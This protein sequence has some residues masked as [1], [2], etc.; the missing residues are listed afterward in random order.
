MLI[1][2]EAHVDTP[3]VLSLYSGGGGLDLGVKRAIPSANTVCYVERELPAIGV[4]LKQIQAGALDDAPIWTDSGTFFGVQ[5]RGLVDWIIGGFPCQPVS[6]AGALKQQ[7]DPRWLWPTIKELLSDIQ[8]SGVF[9]ENVP[10]LL[11]GPI[12]EVLGDLA[13][14][15]YNAEWDVFSAGE[16]GAPHL[17]QRIFILATH[18]E[19][20]RYPQSW[21]SG[22]LTSNSSTRERRDAWQ[23]TN[24]VDALLAGDVSVV[25]REHDGMAQRLDR[26][27]RL[28]IIGNGVVPQ[29]AELALNTLLSRRLTHE[30]YV[31]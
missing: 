20:F 19:R 24:A 26:S 5:W 27:E 3:T 2:E 13:T 21:N 18:P 12:Q 9:L 4:L 10:G 7:A 11:D 29:Q 6:R 14:L 17:R 28:R 25:C 16:V 23:S 31:E 1:K 8:P 22:H 30:H 15:G